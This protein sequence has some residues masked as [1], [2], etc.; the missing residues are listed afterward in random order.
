MGRVDFEALMC[1]RWSRGCFA[2]GCPS[3]LK[4]ASES[5]RYDFD[6]CCG[7]EFWVYMSE[8]LN[9]II[10]QLQIYFIFVYF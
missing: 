10:S 7:F 9:V 2:S 3:Y 4:S 5:E 1:L 8:R 6:D